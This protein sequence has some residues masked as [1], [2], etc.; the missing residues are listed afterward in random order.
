MRI[1]KALAVTAV[2]LTCAVF[3][4]G[5]AA[6]AADTEVWL[7][8]AGSTFAA[9]LYKRWIDVYHKK[10]PSVSGTY[11]SVG[12]GE[13]ISRFVTGSVDYAGTDSPLKDAEAERVSRGVVTIPSAGG[14]VVIAYSLPGLKGTLNLPRD[15]Y[16]DIFAGIITRWDDPRIQAANPEIKL[17]KRNIALVVRLD[18]SGTTDAFTQ[19]LAAVSPSWRG[20]K[21]RAGR[22][23]N[24]PD[25]AMLA[26]GNEGVSS[27]IKISEGAIGYVEYGFAKRLG[28]PVAALENHAGRFV[29]PTD[30]AGKI[31]LSE[32]RALRPQDLNLLI[33][34]PESPLSYP[35][36]TFTWM[37]LY[38]EYKDP[39]KGEALVNFIT[40]GLTEGQSLCVDLGYIPLPERLVG[41]G[42]D[43]LSK[44]RF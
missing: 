12:S 14:M 11:D 22:L 3:T 41:R 30:D 10:N 23:V 34:D 25:T 18:S 5:S 26:R 31:A 39:R 16:P 4:A 28:L 13:G 42:Q 35:I 15:V 20:P 17:P 29:L 37:L 40:W 19:H 24:W 27:R 44:V 21:L 1:I 9:P 38:G 36:V 43:T 33:L 32:A 6:R 2:A 8:G 7:Q